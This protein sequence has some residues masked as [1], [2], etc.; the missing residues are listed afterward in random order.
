MQRTI[1][2]GPS[3]A[4]PQPKMANGQW[5]MADLRGHKRFADLARHSR[6]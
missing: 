5:Q 1:T 6:N 4:P 3:V 2:D